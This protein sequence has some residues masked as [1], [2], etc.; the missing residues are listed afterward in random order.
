MRRLWFKLFGRH[1][2]VHVK[3][4]G[5]DNQIFEPTKGTIPYKRPALSVQILGSNIGSCVGDALGVPVEF[6]T[7][8]ALSANPI[9]GMTGFGTW[10]QPA[11]TWS[12]DSSMILCT[13]E[14]LVEGY[15]LTSI[16]D[17]LLMWYQKGWTSYGK[18]FDIGNTTQMALDYLRSVPSPERAGLYDEYSNGNGSLMRILPLAFITYQRSFEERAQIVADV[19]R[20][21]HA[22]RRFTIA[23]IIL[24]EFACNLLQGYER[25]TSYRLMQDAIMEHLGSELEVTHFPLVYTDIAERPAESI[26]SGG[27]VVETLETAMWCVLKNHSYSD[28]VLSAVNMGGDTDTTGCVAGGLAGLAFGYW[29]IPPEWV[30]A[31]ARREDIK[32]LAQRFLRSLDD[33]ASGYE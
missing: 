33:Q 32:D 19:S 29:D 2:R 12:D 1:R 21:T 16:A 27:Y 23:C 18:V 11:G 25:Y 4:V 28:V 15:S 20:I 5:D 30:N 17:R 6:K 8:S 10:N 14:A 7:R 3:E 31:L 26:H 24:V 22:H 9:A 13:F